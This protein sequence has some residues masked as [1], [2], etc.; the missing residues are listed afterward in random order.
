MSTKK[1]IAYKCSNWVI[2]KNS[3][4]KNRQGERFFCENAYLVPE[5]SKRQEER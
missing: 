3:K 4:V 1:E 5:R 2:E